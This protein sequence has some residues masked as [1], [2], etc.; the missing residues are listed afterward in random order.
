MCVRDRKLVGR[1]SPGTNT[2][3]FLISSFALQLQIRRGRE[4][5]PSSITWSSQ[6]QVNTM[7]VGHSAERPRCLLDRDSEESGSIPDC[8]SSRGVQPRAPHPRGLIWTSLYEHIDPSRFAVFADGGGQTR[9]RGRGSLVDERLH[10]EANLLASRYTG[11]CKV[12]EK[13]LRR[14]RRT[15]RKTEGQ[16]AGSPGL[17]RR[18]RRAT[19]GG[20]YTQLGWRAGE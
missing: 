12:T 16:T 4:R 5:C 2:T 7:P 1:Q 13:A 15:E 9:R 18:S 10:H 11:S 8:S 17:N 6:R 20:P 14:E 19:T 3:K